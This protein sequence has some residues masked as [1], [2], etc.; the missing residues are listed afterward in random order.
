MTTPD[1]SSN[2]DATRRDAGLVHDGGLAPSSTGPGISRQFL[3]SLRQPKVPSRTDPRFAPAPQRS[4]SATST[5][6]TPLWCA[7][8]HQTD[9][10]AASWNYVA[11]TNLG[12]VN[13]YPLVK[14][15]IPVWDCDPG[16]PGTT[17]A[18]QFLTDYQGCGR[19]QAT[20]DALNA[21]PRGMRCVRLQRYD[22]WFPFLRAD[23][24][25][26][27]QGYSFQVPWADNEGAKIRQDVSLIGAALAAQ[28]AVA[29][30]VA[31]D[32]P[33]GEYTNLGFWGPS[34]LDGNLAERTAFIAAITG[35]P[36][37]SQPYFGLSKSL[38]QLYTFDGTYP[39]DFTDLISRTFHPQT[40]RSY[41]R[42]NRAIW[43]IQTEWLNEYLYR[44]ILQSWNPQVKF[45]NFDSM[46]LGPGAD[47]YSINGHPEM[48]PTVAGDGA[49][50]VL[51]ASWNP[52]WDSVYGVQVSDP[53]RLI[54]NN[55]GEPT[56][57]IQA[58]GSAW[59]QMLFL[60]QKIRGVRRENPS[61]PIRPWL[62]S[63][64]WNEDPGVNG[65][66]F[67]S[68]LSDTTGMSLSESKG[69]YWESVRH[70][71]ISSVEMFNLWNWG[72][73]NAQTL[74]QNNQKMNDVLEE[75]NART[76]GFRGPHS[77]S[78]ERVS[79]L[80]DYVATGIGVAPGSWLWRVTA[81]PRKRISPAVPNSSIPLHGGTNFVRTDADG[82]IWMYTDSE[83]PPA[84]ASENAPA[85]W[86]NSTGFG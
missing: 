69:L 18:Q 84:F 30:Y 26:Q 80:A 52:A 9:E 3:G 46:V 72:D 65:G 39:Q 34:P 76:G 35:D 17:T 25:I 53:T 55:Y 23:D 38:L 58:A 32:S 81:N 11:S 22:N 15:M 45:S 66:Y 62:S 4:T 40:N 77:T 36:R 33:P 5:P 75:V 29:D 12:N 51:Y 28:G 21:L 42:W 10:T 49:A 86:S 79:F 60:I 13:R 1:R 56:V 19:F 67:P 2:P 82:G 61:I 59:R 27:Y 8:W 6:A 68:W 24:R 64:S 48:C 7:T 54:R 44:P 50:P 71:A 43:G 16:G 85:G 78:T 74:Q 73:A 70:F 47:V 37:A 83:T 41:L 63:V 20:A 31:L 14:P 57:P